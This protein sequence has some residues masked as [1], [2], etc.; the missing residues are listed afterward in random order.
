MDNVKWRH[1]PYPEGME[2][3]RKTEW[4]TRQQVAEQM[5][6]SLR[7]VRRYMIDGRIRFKRDEMTGRV[8]I[9][10]DSLSTEVEVTTDQY[11]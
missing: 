6:V 2:K 4:I 11:L 3:T 7:T 5:G 8:L 10:A 9:D 1:A